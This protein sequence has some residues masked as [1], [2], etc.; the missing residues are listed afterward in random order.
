MR[1][2]SFFW[3]IG[4]CCGDFGPALLLLDPDEYLDSI[5]NDDIL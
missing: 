5:F 4:Q 2:W 3:Q 1:I